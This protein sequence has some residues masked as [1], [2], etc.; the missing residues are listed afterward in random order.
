MRDTRSL[1]GRV[2]LCVDCHVGAPDQEVDHDLIAAGHPALRFEFG[3]YHALLPR[4]W[5]DRKDRDGRP[6]LE[7]RAWAAGQVASG[8]AALRLLAAHASKDAGRGS[9]PEFA[10]YDCFSCHHD[11]QASSW[12]QLRTSGSSGVPLWGDWYFSALKAALRARTKNPGPSIQ[13][14]TDKVT[15]L[16]KLLDRWNPPREVV[17]KRA[18]ALA[19][20]LEREWL[21]DGDDLKPAEL[22][23]QE[24]IQR[25]DADASLSWDATTQTYLGLAALQHAWKDLHP[26]QHSPRDTLLRELKER[27]DF[28][29]PDMRGPS[30]FV[31]AQLRQLLERGR[32]R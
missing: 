16:K 32:P 14:I 20:Q 6:D 31:P 15:E 25:N 30:H 18:A 17:A 19:Q 22:L 2:R 29:G 9:W 7:A 5:D 4:H 24:L 8:Q 11:L 1:S 26:G 3:S 13:E 23:I 21:G 28:P 10:D 27:L 12:R